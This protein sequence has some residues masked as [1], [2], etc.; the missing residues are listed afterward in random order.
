MSSYERRS[1]E[2]RMTPYP[3]TTRLKAKSFLQNSSF[4]I[5][6]GCN[7]SINDPPH[8]KDQSIEGLEAGLRDKTKTGA[9][10]VLLQCWTEE[11]FALCSQ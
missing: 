11:A 5:T 8:K 10:H 4:I 2:L 6:G 9:N 7:Y 1:Y 3:I